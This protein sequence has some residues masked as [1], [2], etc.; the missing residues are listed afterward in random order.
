MY[1]ADTPR[2]LV[3]IRKARDLGFTLAEIAQLLALSQ[4]HSAGAA[5]VKERAQ[6]KL[7]DLD[8]RLAEMEE[9]RRSLSLLVRACSGHGSSDSCPILA[10][11]AGPERQL[12]QWNGRIGIA[13]DFD[14]PLPP[15]IAELFD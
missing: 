1:G 15:E 10:A 3:F 14:A 8:R 5:D 13:S 9:M 11:L 4:D 6:Q 2:R 12:G 7:H